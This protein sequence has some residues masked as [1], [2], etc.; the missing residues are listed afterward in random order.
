VNTKELYK[1]IKKL[2]EKYS[3]SYKEM[4]DILGKKSQIDIPLSIFNKT[5]GSLESIIKYL[6]EELQLSVK[7][8][9]F[10]TNRKQQ[11]VRTTYNRT[12]KKHPKRLDITAKNSIPITIIQDTKLSVLENL[13]SFFIKNNYSINQ[14]STLLKRDY[15]T[16][17]TIKNRIKNK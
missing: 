9:S 13:V 14:I 16:I 11:P 3:L 8:I 5:L 17:W 12:Q 1:D 6:K 7:E 2:E 4:L 10:L 15:K